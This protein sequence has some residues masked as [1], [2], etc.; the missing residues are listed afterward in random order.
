MIFH[1]FVSNVIRNELTIFLRQK[2]FRVF[3][4]VLRKK[5]ESI[6]KSGLND[7]NQLQN[8]ISHNISIL[9]DFL[10]RSGF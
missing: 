5:C 1:F 6:F 7:S 9:K 3:C 8:E 10:V 4:F 2:K